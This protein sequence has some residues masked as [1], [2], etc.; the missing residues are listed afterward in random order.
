MLDFG[1]HM[2]DPWCRVGDMRK[3]LDPISLAMLNYIA[4]VEQAFGTLHRPASSMSD[5]SGMVSTERKVS[6]SNGMA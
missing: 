6:D 2:S 4:A 1:L 3:K 5:P